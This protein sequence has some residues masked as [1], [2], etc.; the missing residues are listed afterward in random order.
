MNEQSNVLPSPSPR[1]VFWFTV[2]ITVTMGTH[3]LAAEFIPLGDLPGGD[4][5]SGA[6][7]VSD[8]GRTV[9]GRG[10]VGADYNDQRLFRWVDG[11]IEQLSE[12]HVL[13]TDAS[14]DGSLAVGFYDGGWRWTQ[15]TGLIPLVTERKK[16]VETGPAGVSADGSII[17][18]AQP[19][20][21]DSFAFRWTE[22]TGIVNLGTLFGQNNS[23]A[24]DVSADGNVVVGQGYLR[25]GKTSTPRVPIYWDGDTGPYEI[26]APASFEW[27][28]GQADAVSSDGTVVTGWGHFGDGD[29]IG[30]RWERITGEMT[31][32]GRESFS[33][34]ASP[35]LTVPRDISFAGEFLVGF[36]TLATG[37][38]ARIWDALHGARDLKDVLVLE[39][40]LGIELVGWE[41]NVASKI[42]PDGQN[43]VGYGTNPLGDTEAF[44][45]R[46]GGIAVT[47]VPEPKA[48]LLLFGAAFLLGAARDLHTATMV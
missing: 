44:L 5:H 11:T 30:F 13:V 43:I 9:F 6:F 28:L 33:T 38:D 16:V 10:Q 4:F 2:L 39:Y 17:V 3:L 14:A 26:P 40:G 7:A 31:L 45:V 25:R 15:E 41:L 34:P 22:S 21:R 42:S 24:H 18:G 27:S 1:S 29:T 8:D 47:A 46:L 19:E 32:T 12:S 36:E 23:S 20:G 37:R 48:A 35:Q